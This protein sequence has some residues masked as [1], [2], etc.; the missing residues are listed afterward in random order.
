MVSNKEKAKRKHLKELNSLKN[1]MGSNI[2]WFD[3]LNF[4]AKMDILFEWKHLKK[5]NLIETT[6]TIKRG[7][8]M[9]KLYP[10]SFKHFI[11]KM[12]KKYRSNTVNIRNSSIEFLLK[13]NK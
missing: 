6:T 4:K 11:L 2:I 12:R 1:K 9:V 5:F 13:N 7:R 3:S 8:K 10:V